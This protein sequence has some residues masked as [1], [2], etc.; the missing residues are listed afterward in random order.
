MRLRDGPRVAFTPS[1]SRFP[2]VRS[3]G[4]L[5]SGRKHAR[6]AKE[7][8]Y[9]SGP[10]ITTISG[11]TRQGLRPSESRALSCKISTTF[12]RGQ[13]W[14]PRRGQPAG[15]VTRS[16][17][18]KNSACSR[19]V[20]DF[21]ADLIGTL[22]LSPNGDKMPPGRR[23]GDAALTLARPLGSGQPKQARKLNCSG[24][25]Y[26]SPKGAPTGRISS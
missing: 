15:L 20:S 4:K 3:F 12:R 19:P 11:R 5:L 21:T 13:S 22:V 24:H 25:R 9:H 26:P 18:G 6:I 7:L 10:R 17:L 2:A 23:I 16:P 14:R 1:D 8:S